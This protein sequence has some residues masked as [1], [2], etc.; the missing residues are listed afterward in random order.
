MLIDHQAENV[1]QTADNHMKILEQ[2]TSHDSS[3]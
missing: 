2:E 3:V 1:K